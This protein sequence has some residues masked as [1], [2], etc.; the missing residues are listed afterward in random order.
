M[1][2]PFL[3]GFRHDIKIVL[4]FFAILLNHS[5]M[6]LALSEGPESCKNLEE[7]MFKKKQTRTLT[8]N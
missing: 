7:K 8:K 4:F 5:G 1:L 6:V 3:N 2:G